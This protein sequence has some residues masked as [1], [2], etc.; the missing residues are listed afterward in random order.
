MREAEGDSFAVALNPFFFFLAD[1]AHFY[2]VSSLKAHSITDKCVTH[3][4]I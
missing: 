1:S 3:K 2:H 4:R